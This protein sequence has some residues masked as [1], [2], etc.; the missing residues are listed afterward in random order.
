ANAT[1]PLAPVEREQFLAELHRELTNHNE[2]ADGS[3]ARVLRDLQRRHFK[4]PAVEEINE[5]ARDAPGAVPSARWSGR[6]RI[7]I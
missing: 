4:P 3:L 1:R 2:I 5:R 6:Y 7:K